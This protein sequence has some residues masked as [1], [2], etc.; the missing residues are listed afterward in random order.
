MSLSYSFHNK[1]TQDRDKDCYGGSPAVNVLNALNARSES[2]IGEEQKES[3]HFSSWANP[4]DPSRD[5]HH[6]DTPG[7]HREDGQ[8]DLMRIIGIFPLPSLIV[9]LCF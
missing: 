3:G 8:H 4:S 5:N 9:R 1:E 2:S 7:R 6:Y